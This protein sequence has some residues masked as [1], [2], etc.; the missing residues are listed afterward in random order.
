MKTKKKVLLL[1]GSGALGSYLIPQLLMMNYNIHVVSLDELK[2]DNPNLTY[3]KADVKNDDWLKVAL[4]TKYDA[5]VDFMIY[6]TNEFKTRYDFLMNSTDHYVFLSSYRVYADANGPITEDSP[7]LLDVIKDDS[8]FLASD[9]Y[10]LAKAHCEDFITSSHYKNWTILRPAIT[11]SSRKY[12]LITMEANS[13]I[14]R[15]LENKITVLPEIA[16]DKQATLTWAGDTGKMISRLILNNKA[17]G[18]KY[19]VATAEHH[20]W[21]EFADYYKEL[22]GMKYITTDTETFLEI[23]DGGTLWARWRLM[24][25]RVYDRV[26]DNSKILRDTGL[27]QEDLT[28]IKEA[29]RKELSTLPEDNSW[30]HYSVASIIYDE[31][32]G[33]MDRYTAQHL[34]T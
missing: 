9:D 2:S 26:C 21:R 7:R 6:S 16:M 29:L 8:D 17:Y 4:T 33:K 30:C 14:N 12:Q 22:I 10:A 27:S 23:F 20:T 13:F 31:I 34:T 5:I 24:Y 3:E 32:N 18:Q 28:P 25:D 11:F 19:T 1:G 15:A